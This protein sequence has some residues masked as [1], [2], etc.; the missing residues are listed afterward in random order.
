MITVILRYEIIQA[1]S[2]VFVNHVRYADN[3]D[4]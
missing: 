1:L 3:N 4:T 2:I